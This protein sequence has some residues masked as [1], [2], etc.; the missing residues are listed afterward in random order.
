MKN[1]TIRVEDEVAHWAR[2]RAAEQNTSISRML[3][4]MLRN[5]MTQKEAVEEARKAYMGRARK[6]RRPLSD[7]P[8]PNRES[9][10]DR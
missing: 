10:Y 2:I 1:I 5:E 6:R 7:K 9:L 8:Y 3:G 4:E